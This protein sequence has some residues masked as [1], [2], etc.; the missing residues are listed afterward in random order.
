MTNLQIIV[1]AAV[2]AGIFTEDEVKARLEAGQDLPLHT[3]QE[4]K[5]MGY[6]V[7]RGETAALKCDIWR[8]KAEKQA[9][10]TKDG[11]EQ[12]IDMSHYYKKTAF[13]F[14]EAQVDKVGR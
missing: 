9:V 8:F 14:T 2:E 13:F 11:D 1:N 5:R 3:Y 6:Q 7:R 10:E 4:W 12:E